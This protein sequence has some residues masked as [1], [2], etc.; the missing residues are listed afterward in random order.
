MNIITLDARFKGYH[1]FKYAIELHGQHAVKTF[2]E[3]RVWCW[4]TFGPSTERDSAL[5]MRESV[6]TWSWIVEDTTT[7][8]YFKDS[9]ELTMFKL[10]WG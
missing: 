4:E 5:K 2:H 9:E 10:K 8:I 1:K 6:W 3:M 7:R